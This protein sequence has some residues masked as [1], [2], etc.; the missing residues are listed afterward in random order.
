[1]LLNKHWIR[2]IFISIKIFGLWHR[3]TI[4]GGR[5]F[6]QRWPR[7]YPDYNSAI[8][9]GRHGFREWHFIPVLTTIQQRAIQHCLVPSS[10]ILGWRHRDTILTSI[11]RRNDNPL[12]NLRS[13]QRA[14]LNQLSRCFEDHSRNEPSTS[15]T[16]DEEVDYGS[17]GSSVNPSRLIRT[18]NGVH[19]RMI[20][21][22]K[23]QGCID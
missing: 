10:V 2:F 12:T 6:Q 22:T 9:R 11:I 15:G 23:W 4:L 16:P 5:A 1:M 20:V 18:I 17:C 19:L 13:R 14:P 21:N 3:T 8:L 7:Q